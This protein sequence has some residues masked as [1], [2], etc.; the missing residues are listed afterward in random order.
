MHGICSF[1]DLAQPLVARL[2]AQLGYPA[3]SVEAVACARNKDL[4]R[5]ALAAAG[6]PT[7]A[8]MLIQQPG[9]LAEAAAT[10]GFPSVLKPVGGSESIGVVRVDSE[11][12]LGESYAQLQ[13]L[14]RATAYKDGSLSTFDDEDQAQGSVS[15]GGGGRSIGCRCMAVRAVASRPLGVACCLPAAA[16]RPHAVAGCCVREPRAPLV[17]A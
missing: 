3:N 8:H 14:M 12:Q 7:P 5:Q 17:A 9:Q 16:S 4:T 15:G 6:L 2:C 11:E 10:V 13:A 1:S